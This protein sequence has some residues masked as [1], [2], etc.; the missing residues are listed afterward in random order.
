MCLYTSVQS[1]V[2]RISVAFEVFIRA[3]SI[4]LIRMNRSKWEPF[5]RSNGINLEEKNTHSSVCN[6]ELQRMNETVMFC[7]CAWIHAGM[8][9]EVSGL[10]CICPP[11]HPVFPHQRWVPSRV[12]RDSLPAGDCCCLSLRAGALH[13]DGLHLQLATNRLQL[14]DQLIINTIF[15]MLL[16]RMINPAQAGRKQI[17]LEL[18]C[19]F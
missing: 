3:Y 11:T 16:C 5:P 10:P 2:H 15:S 9:T 14:H 1:I 8:N 6:S 18:F 13:A 4:I 17:Y 7:G 19:W 12:V